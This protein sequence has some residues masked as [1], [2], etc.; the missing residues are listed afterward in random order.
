MNVNIYRISVEVT[1]HSTNL[2]KVEGECE[3][4]NSQKILLYDSHK[5]ATERPHLTPRG[6]AI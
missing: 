5:K 2:W 3:A 1:N 6:A 4:E